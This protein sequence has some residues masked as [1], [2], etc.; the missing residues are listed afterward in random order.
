MRLKKILLALAFVVAGTA[1]ASWASLG[2]PGN[3]SDDAV[4][5]ARTCSPAC[6]KPKTCTCTYFQGEKDTG[7]ACGAEDDN[8]AKGRCVCRCA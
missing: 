6:P 7:F 5:M 1:G 8:A 4:P 3:G 2:V